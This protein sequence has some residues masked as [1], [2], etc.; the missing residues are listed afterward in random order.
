MVVR[1]CGKQFQQHES[2]SPT[3]V[4]TINLFCL[5]SGIH[6]IASSGSRVSYIYYNLNTLKVEQDCLFPAE[7]HALLGR[8]DYPVMLH[9]CQEVERR[10][11]KLLF[12]KSEVLL[13]FL[14]TVKIICSLYA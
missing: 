7:T 4:S 3:S 2:I 9:N 1:I 6:L 8:S 5:L 13:T 14:V 10:L 11:V 12:I